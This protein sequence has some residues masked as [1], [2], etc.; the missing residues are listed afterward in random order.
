MMRK[1]ANFI[2]YKLILGVVVSP[3]IY[4]TKVYNQTRFNVFSYILGDGYG[5]ISGRL[6]FIS[7][8][9]N[10]LSFFEYLCNFFKV[11]PEQKQSFYQNVWG[12]VFKKEERAKNL[13]DV[14][15][16]L[17]PCR[18][19]AVE[20]WQEKLFSN[21]DKSTSVVSEFFMHLCGFQKQKEK[22]FTE[23]LISHF[24]DFV[25]DMKEVAAENTTLVYF[26]LAVIVFLYFLLREKEEDDKNDWKTK[27]GN[28]M[29]DLIE[30]EEFNV[31]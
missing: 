24:T 16:D 23:V 27:T 7:T 21:V 25:L 11:K 12:N 6:F 13:L 3:L 5:E 20:T 8:T 22:S 10:K 17:L 2:F 1:H 30:C 26:T 28:E 31:V 29:K 14:F 4:F 19:K 9:E 15:F 18:E